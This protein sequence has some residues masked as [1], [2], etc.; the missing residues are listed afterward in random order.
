M[1]AKACST[2]AGSAGAD[3]MRH[4]IPLDPASRAVI[5]P[6]PNSAPALERAAELPLTATHSM[7]TRS[8]GSEL[9]CFGTASLTPSAT[10]FLLPEASATSVGVVTRRTARSAE[11]A[12]T[13]TTPLPCWACHGNDAKRESC[14]AVLAIPVPLSMLLLLACAG[15]EMPGLCFATLPLARASCRWLGAVF[16]EE[17]VEGWK[18]PGAAELAPAAARMRAAMRASARCSL[19]RRR[20]SLVARSTVPPGEGEDK[21]VSKADSRVLKMRGT[22]GN[23]TE[24]HAHHPAADALIQVGHR[25]SASRF[26]RC[27]K[28][29]SHWDAHI[30]RG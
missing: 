30:V 5:L 21:S 7:V 4:L 6:P 27:H 25:N 1:S 26:R 13:E 8:F 12:D 3:D 22:I 16:S 2:G 17:F 29:C 14:P 20:R 18:S 10:T 24:L 11:T 9:C 23:R 19:I 28:F 15:A